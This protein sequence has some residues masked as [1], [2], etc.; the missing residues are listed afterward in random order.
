MDCAL[1]PFNCS[2]VLLV[3]SAI[4]SGLR[5]REFLPERREM[6]LYT[7]L[8]LFQKTFALRW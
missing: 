6:K 3:V 1:T 2:D 4:V 5:F 7:K 8:L